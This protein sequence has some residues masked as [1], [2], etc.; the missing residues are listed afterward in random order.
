MSRCYLTGAVGPA[1]CVGSR[2]DRDFA[3][4][5]WANAV[6]FSTC[7]DYNLM[8][9]YKSLGGGVGGLVMS[10]FHKV[11]VMWSHQQERLNLNNLYWP[12]LEYEN[13]DNTLTVVFSIFLPFAVYEAALCDDTCMLSAFP[14]RTWPMW[15]KS[16]RVDMFVCV[17]LSFQLE[18]H[19]I[20]FN[21]QHSS[22]ISL[23]TEWLSLPAC[24]DLV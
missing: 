21:L 17:Q 3:Y 1:W 7:H 15:L 20:L 6:H 2:Y 12:G 8:V 10:V 5:L 13:N 14:V 16:R 4:T 24:V 22:S 23:S 19:F 11:D 18:P 9:R